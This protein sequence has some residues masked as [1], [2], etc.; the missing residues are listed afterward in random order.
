MDVYACDICGTEE[1]RTV[2]LKCGRYQGF[3][4][5]CCL[6]CR[7]RYNAF[8]GKEIVTLLKA[9]NE[10]EKEPDDYWKG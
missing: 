6:K 1:S 9:L 5:Q 3:D 2:H 7:N 4:F 10:L 8:T